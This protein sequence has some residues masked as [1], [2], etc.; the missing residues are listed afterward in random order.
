MISSATPALTGPRAGQRRERRPFRRYLALF[1]AAA[2]VAGLP[3][4]AN[5]L[6]LRSAGETLPLAEIA[7]RQQRDGGIYFSGVHSSERSYK[8]ELVALRQ[9]EFV[10]LGSSRSHQFRAEAFS[11]PFVCVCG[12][13]KSL[14]DIDA[15]AAAM[16]QIGKPKLV[17]LTLDWWWFI[18]GY[19][20]SEGLGP[21]PPRGTETAI[22]GA[23]LLRPWQWVLEGSIGVREYFALLGG[24]TSLNEVTQRPKYGIQAVKRALGM[25]KD[26]S[27]LKGAVL[28]GIYADDV[29][30]L[31]YDLE[32][33]DRGA[34]PWP[35]GAID[36]DAFKLLDA[37]LR[38]FDA[39]DTRVILVLPP[40]MRAIVDRLAAKAEYAAI[41]P[42]R[43]R[44]RALPRA[45]HDFHDP[46]TIGSDDCEFLDGRHGGDVTAL[47]ALREIVRRNPDGAL[48][49]AVD[50]AA[51]DR[52][53]ARFA[54]RAFA[55]YEPQADRLVETDFLRIGCRK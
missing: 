40:F 19:A 30:R 49:G 54:G 43:A 55:D 13:A 44:L 53:I 1:A 3:F 41:E 22:D 18:E 23:K 45:V 28:A 14:A 32:R 6:V 26:G 2:I 47:R 20:K 39:A 7:A 36:E 5:Y 8:L 34:A 9:P 50:A 21:I 38:R 10:A 51:L 33:I 35:H 52:D 12:I 37:V 31:A 29:D 17:I 24:V 48:A 11:A 46:R 27:L 16:L 42:I 25:R 15:M 4:A